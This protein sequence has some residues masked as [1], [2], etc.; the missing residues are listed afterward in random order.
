LNLHIITNC[1]VFEVRFDPIE[2][3][4][5]GVSGSILGL[6][7][8]ELVDVAS[9][10]EVLIDCV[11]LENDVKVRTSLQQDSELTSRVPIH[12]LVPFRGPT[13]SRL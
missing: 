2:Q 1:C 6:R 5:F 8:G 10:A 9:Y 4:F 13:S 7:V 11:D 3:V 12:F